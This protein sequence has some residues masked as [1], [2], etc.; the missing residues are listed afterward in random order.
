[1]NIASSRRALL[2]CALAVAAVGVGCFDNVEG[3]YSDTTGAAKMELKD[4][5]ANMDFGGIRIDG[6]YK[7]EGDK[8]L[9][10]STEGAPQTVS[11]TINGDGSLEAPAGAAFPK[12]AKIK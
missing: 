5:K 9:I 8:L 3:K 4:G 2:I 7:V 12:L 1:M 6:T 11:F 10:Q